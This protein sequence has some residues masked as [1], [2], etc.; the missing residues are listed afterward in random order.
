M[1]GLM[2]HVKDGQRV[3]L[4]NVR[5]GFQRLGELV[6]EIGLAGAIDYAMAMRTHAARQYLGFNAEAKPISL[7]TKDARYPLYARRSTSDLEVFE[8]IFV[9]KE[10]RPLDDMKSPKAIVDCGAYVGYST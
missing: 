5:Q 3:F 9:K 1:K 7:R 8:D 6:H 4:G 2:P 10:Y